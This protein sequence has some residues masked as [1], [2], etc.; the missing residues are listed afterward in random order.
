MNP[1]PLIVNAGDT[2]TWLRR[3]DQCQYPDANGNLQMPLASA[4]WAL[5]YALVIT[6][7]QIQINATASGDDFLVLVPAATTAAYTIGTY[8]WVAYVTN[9]LERYQIDNGT[10]QINPNL[11]T[12]T[13]GYDNRSHVKKV[14]DALETAIEGTATRSQLDLIFYATGNNNVRRD[15]AQLIVWH[16]RYK[17]MYQQEVAG[18]KIKKGMD[19]GNTIYARF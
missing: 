8:S 15:R 7:T 12:Q 1:E 19:T 5:S 18:E 11:A 2:I 13:S 3:A 9:A 16:N 17:F 4:G 10:I 14:L 6:G